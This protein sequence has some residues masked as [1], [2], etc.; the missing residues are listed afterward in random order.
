M[1][2]KEIKGSNSQEQTQRC[3]SMSCQY[4][5][6][7]K[8]QLRS[9][10]RLEENQ[11]KIQS[12]LQYRR[13]RCRPKPSMKEQNDAIKCN[14]RVQSCAT[15]H[16]EQFDDGTLSV[17]Q[18]IAEAWN[19]ALSAFESQNLT[20]SNPSHAN[21]LTD[22]N[23]S[24]SRHHISCEYKQGAYRRCNLGASAKCLAPKQVHK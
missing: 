14:N 11:N 17:R 4:V 12:K 22:K 3:S 23:R 21:A 6:T 9:K 10:M 13:P 18:K 5:G 7:P 1:K 2:H 15:Q 16:L 19:D 8:R 24:R 20:K